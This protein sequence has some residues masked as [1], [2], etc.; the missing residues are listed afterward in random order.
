MSKVRMPIEEMLAMSS[1]GTAERGL[2]CPK[3]HCVQFRGGQS[4]RNVR[5][6]EGGIK[7]Y[8]TCRAC[9]K[10]WCTIER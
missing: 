7:R 5:H 2:K 3:C 1:Q 10:V 4:I 6:V 9:G 8:R